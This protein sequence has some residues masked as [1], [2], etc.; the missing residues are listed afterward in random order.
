MATRV[1]ATGL[2]VLALASQA[3]W[4]SPITLQAQSLMTSPGVVAVDRQD[5]TAVQFCDTISWLAYKASWLHAQISQ[6]DRRVLLLDSSAPSG[7]AALAVWVEGQGV[8]LQLLVR[9][10]STTLANH[11][12]FVSCAQPQK[13]AA[14]AQP[15]A[16]PAQPAAAGSSGAGPAGGPT[17]PSS[18]RA[19]QA[20]WDRFVSGLSPRQWDLLKALI[21]TPSADTYA[22]FTGSLSPQQAAAWAVLAPAAHLAPP[23]SAPQQAA[24]PGGVAYQAPPSWL[25][26]QARAA[27]GGGEILIAYTVTNTGTAEVVL[28]SARL[29]VLDKDGRPL[30]GVSVSRQDS[31]GLEGRVPA[32]G[33]ESGVIRVPVPESGPEVIVRWPAVEIGTGT[34]YMLQETLAGS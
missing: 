26:W 15:P 28:D 9:A 31:S 13:P 3:A 27:K 17:P 24:Q 18:S 34:T 25:V 2:A 33:L 6:Q 8:P 20:D 10:S 4:A 16:R 29:Q 14:Q 30:R 5:V 11:L 23:A 12:Y 22:A 32:G 19:P 21:A 7:E 1:A